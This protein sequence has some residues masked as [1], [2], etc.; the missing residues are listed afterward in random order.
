[1]M[2]PVPLANTNNTFTQSTRDDSWQDKYWDIILRVRGGSDLLKDHP[3]IS[4]GG[5][6]VSRNSQS[7]KGEQESNDRPDNQNLQGKSHSGSRDSRITGADANGGLISGSQCKDNG[8]PGNIQAMDRRILNQ[9]TDLTSFDDCQGVGQPIHPRDEQPSNKRM[10]INAEEFGPPNICKEFIETSDMG[11]ERLLGDEQKRVV[12]GT[13]EKTCPN[14]GV[15]R[16]DTQ[17]LA[18]TRKATQDHY[19]EC[20]GAKSCPFGRME[21]SSH[22]VVL[23]FIPRQIQADTPQITAT[24]AA[25]QQH[26]NTPSATAPASR[27]PA[28]RPHSIRRRSGRISPIGGAHRSQNY[29]PKLNRP[30][31]RKTES[32]ARGYH[33]LHSRNRL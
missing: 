15:A 31:Q 4:N 10:V 30:H 12:G 3:T 9:I 16:R 27:I 25:G 20:R 32:W 5:Q 33:P 29:R 2:S 17:S 1:M 18:A 6:R 7:S 11:R 21:T 24:H 14:E 26:S 22:N 28:D 19:H 8:S 13:R 23:D